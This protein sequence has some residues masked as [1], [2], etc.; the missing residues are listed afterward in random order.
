MT[1][2]SHRTRINKMG[3]PGQADV[4]VVPA[5]NTIS[6]AFMQKPGSL[7][8]NIVAPSVKVTTQSG[9]YPQYPRGFFFR[10]DMALRADG[11]E[12]AG[13]GFAVDWSPQYNADVWAWH[14]DIGPQVRAN[15]TMV[16][17]DTAATTLCSQKALIRRE[18]LF[19]TKYFQPGVWTTNIVG[20]TSGG[21]G[22]NAAGTLGWR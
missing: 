15:S 6:V 22:T 4:Y 8:A 20:A 5:L 18:K 7:I 3:Q 1:D 19:L 9:K 2:F 16:D 21:G 17:V 13:G 10:D 12:S 14:T 11:S